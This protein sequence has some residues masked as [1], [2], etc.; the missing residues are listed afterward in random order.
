MKKTKPI[1]YFD[2]DGVLA[3]FDGAPRALDRYKTEKGFFQTLAP[4][5]SGLNRAKTLIEKGYQVYV[6]TAS[7]HSRADYD[8]R[9]WLE[10]YLPSLKR[11]HFIAVRLGACKADYVRDKSAQNV[12]FDDYT[13][14]LN[15]WRS[16][17]YIA[18]E[19]H[20]TK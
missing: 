1:V 14:N 20:G 6:L 3:D 10:R 7:P 2:M 11:S 8:K 19:F 9:R 16:R 15:A 12:L 13:L 18:F 17:G 4:L 5:T